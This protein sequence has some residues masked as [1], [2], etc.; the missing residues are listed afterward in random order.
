MKSTRNHLLAVCALAIGCL[1]PALPAQEGPPPSSK[2]EAN[3]RAFAMM[4]EKLGLTDE[5]ADKIKAIRADERTQLDALRAKEGDRESK[6][7]EMKAI[8]ADTEAKVDAV[9][10][11]EQREKAA[12]MREEMKARMGD[13]GSKAPPAGEP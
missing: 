2:K 13:K 7:E 4:K 11:P 10:T 8:R 9:L 6:R 5:Q 1:L 3:P 12:K